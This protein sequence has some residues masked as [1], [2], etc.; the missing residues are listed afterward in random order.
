MRF[1][2]SMLL[3]MLVA[4]CGGQSATD[5]PLIVE[6][7][8]ATSA[9][10]APQQRVV[11]NDIAWQELWGLVGQPAPQPLRPGAVGVAVFLG[12]KPTAGYGI[13]M[14]WSKTSDGALQVRWGEIA[15]SPGSVAGQMITQPWRIAMLQADGKPVMLAEGIVREIENENTV[16]ENEVEEEVEQEGPDA[17]PGASG[18]LV[19]DA[20]SPSEPPVAAQEI[21]EDFQ[22]MDDIEEG[23]DP[24]EAWD[25]DMPSQDENT[26]EE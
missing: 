12:E 10:A 11:T 14:Q 15:P 23:K 21:Q 6:W 9:T 3:L 13:D 7:R 24:G 19:D 26:D 17:A 20:P 16:V 5:T 4:A 22:D 18:P 8:G 1:G 25:N 2:F